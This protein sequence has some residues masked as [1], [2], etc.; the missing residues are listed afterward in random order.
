MSDK[1]PNLSPYTYCANNPVRLVDKDGRTYFEIEGERKHINDGHDNITV[2]NVTEKQFNRLQRNFSKGHTSRYNT[3]FNKFKNH[4]GYIENTTCG[5]GYMNENGVYVLP[6]IRCTR[7]TGEPYFREKVGAFIRKIDEGGSG[8]YFDRKFAE[9]VEPVATS[10]ALIM[11]SVSFVNSLNTIF[12]GEDIYGTQA[13]AL[14]YTLSAVGAVA[15]PA[16]N[17]FNVPSAVKWAD[18]P[19]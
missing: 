11:P 4:N 5:D 9:A 12:T 15:G 2:L 17:F 16:N 19:I 18:Q 1:Y 8:D 10:A 14:D 13:N 3:L 6:E 7:H